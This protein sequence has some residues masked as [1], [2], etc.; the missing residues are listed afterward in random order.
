MQRIVQ[1]QEGEE[2]AVSAK[3]LIYEKMA[4]PTLYLFIAGM[5]IAAMISGMP[6][7]SVTIQLLQLYHDAI[8]ALLGL[9]DKIPTSAIIPIFSS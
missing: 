3:P 4:L 5:V 7:G 8:G 6:D 9:A 2:Q 1:R